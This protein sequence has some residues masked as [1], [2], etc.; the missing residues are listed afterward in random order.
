MDEEE[1]K[2]GGLKLD[3]DDELD[4]PPEGIDDFGIDDD[5]DDR[6]H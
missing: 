2:E 6:Y 3:G 1:E 5:P 4:M